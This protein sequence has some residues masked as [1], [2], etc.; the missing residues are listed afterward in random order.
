MENFYEV[1][2]AYIYGIGF[3]MVGFG[4]LKYMKIEKNKETEEEKKNKDSIN[5]TTDIKLYIGGYGGII[6]G[7][8]CILKELLS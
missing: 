7:I 8:I 2:K 6:L 4:V 5:K 1:Y 3:M